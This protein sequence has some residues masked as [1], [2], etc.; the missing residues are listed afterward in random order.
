MNLSN[1][2]KSE[3]NP[4]LEKKTLLILRWI[5]IIGQLIAIYTVHFVFNFK[6]PVLYC[7]LII[8]FGAITNIYL[9]LWFKKNELSTLDSTFFY[10]TIFFS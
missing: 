2:F 10:F 6:L 3:E 9:Q 7:S 4:Q 8:F 5:A 1:L